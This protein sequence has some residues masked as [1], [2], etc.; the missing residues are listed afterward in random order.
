MKLHEQVKELKKQV[1]IYEAD[2]LN[3][4]RY[5]TSDKFHIDNQVNIADIFLRLDELQAKLLQCENITT[6]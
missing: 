5:L 6:N 2:I 1:A 4:R 3:L